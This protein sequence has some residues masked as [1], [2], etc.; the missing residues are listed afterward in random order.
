M[1]NCYIHQK[2]RNVTSRIVIVTIMQTFKSIFE[3]INSNKL[4]HIPG[5][6]SIV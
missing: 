5:S 1:S 4:S 3:V 2:T 6:V